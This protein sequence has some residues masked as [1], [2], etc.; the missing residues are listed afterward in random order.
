MNLQ[1]IVLFQEQ[2][3]ELD[4]GTSDAKRIDRS[5]PLADFSITVKERLL[6]L[7]AGINLWICVDGCP[8]SGRIPD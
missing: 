5:A 7:I 4:L 1:F 8:D 6:K 2:S 3:N